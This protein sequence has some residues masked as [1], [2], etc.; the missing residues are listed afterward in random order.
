MHIIHTHWTVAQDHSL[1]AMWLICCWMFSYVYKLISSYFFSTFSE[2]RC[3]RFD[4]HFTS[5]TPIVINI[6]VVVLNVFKIIWHF[7]EGLPVS[8]L[9]FALTGLW[10]YNIVFANCLIKY[11]CFYMYSY[12]C[13]QISYIVQG[14]WASFSK[15][16]LLCHE[17]FNF[18]QPKLFYPW[19][20]NKTKIRRNKDGYE[21]I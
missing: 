10:Q 9:L 8:T 14:R 2:L 16:S 6:F 3:I 17:I 11:R 7:I 4:R 19:V 12:L 21:T 5:S 1:Y 18:W 15:L 13:W 20:N